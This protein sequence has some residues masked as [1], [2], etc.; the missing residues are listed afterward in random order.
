M[1]EVKLAELIGLIS[2]VGF[3]IQQGLELIDPFTTLLAEKVKDAC[4]IFAQIDL[5]AIKHWIVAVAAFSFGLFV[6][7]SMDIGLL[8]EA[9]IESASQAKTLD[10]IV[11]GFA[12]GAGSEG[13]N[14]A[15][16]FLAYVKEARKGPALGLRSQLAA[17]A[18]AP[19]ND[20]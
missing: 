17:S 19:R 13:V 9:G 16:K 12:F 10:V 7:G 2:I 6:A 11:T 1:D 18:G 5:E 14:S 4:G 20:D 15:Q 3:A 8:G